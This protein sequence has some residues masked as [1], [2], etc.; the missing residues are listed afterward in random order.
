M[1]PDDN[2]CREYTLA[3]P[4]GCWSYDITLTITIFQGYE[5]FMYSMPN[6]TDQPSLL[7]WTGSNEEQQVGAE[8]NVP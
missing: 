1:F 8:K 5:S 7:H 6:M 3:V 4:G 2:E